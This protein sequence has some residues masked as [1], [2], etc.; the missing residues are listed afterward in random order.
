M[1]VFGLLII[2]SLLSIG[3][4]ISFAH[5]LIFWAYGLWT[6]GLIVALL[7]GFYLVWRRS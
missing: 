6:A 3:G 7:A 1:I 5:G 4:V 2:A